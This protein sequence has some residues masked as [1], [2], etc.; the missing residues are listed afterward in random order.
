MVHRGLGNGTLARERE[1]LLS[2]RLASG[3][4]ASGKL[5][6]KVGSAEAGK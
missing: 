3:R 2:G 6:S 5:A 1:G 4:L